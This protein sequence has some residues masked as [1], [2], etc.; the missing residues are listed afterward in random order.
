MK[1]L[2]PL[3]Y[4]VALGLICIPVL[5]APAL[6]IEG[7]FAASAMEYYDFAYKVDSVSGDVTITGIKSVFGPEIVIRAVWNEKPVTAISSSAFA[8][9]M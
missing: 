9:K 5:C 8:E 7:N 1:K 4:S 2:L 6:G 3:L